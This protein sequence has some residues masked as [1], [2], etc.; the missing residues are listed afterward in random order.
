MADENRIGFVSSYN[1]KTGMAAITYPD[2]NNETTDELP[3]FT[4]LGLIQ[5]LKK[6]DAVLVV[7]LSNNSAAGI[8][9]GSYSA[10]GSVPAAGILV[11]DRGLVLQDSSG[12]ISLSKIIAKCG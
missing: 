11:S 3:V 6:G 2:R 8:V 7:H 12:S 5:N 10:A 1:A 9:L 4:P